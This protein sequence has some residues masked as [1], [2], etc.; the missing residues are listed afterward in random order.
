M[1]DGVQEY[2][3]MKM[4]AAI[5]KND[6]RVSMIVNKVIGKP[7]GNNAV[8]NLHVWNYDPKKWDESRKELGLLINQANKNPSK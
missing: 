7:F 4:L 5:D 3:Y 8:G 6:S 2:E 1:R